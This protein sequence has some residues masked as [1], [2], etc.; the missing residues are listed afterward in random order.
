MARQDGQG[1]AAA[2][3]FIMFFAV[4][5]PSMTGDRFCCSWAGWR[6]AAGL[7]AIPVLLLSLTVSLAS[8]T[9]HLRLAHQSVVQSSVS[10]NVRQH[11]DRD[12]VQWTPP[13]PR[14]TVLEA[15]GFDNRWAPAGP[16]LPNQLWHDTLY[17]RPP[18]SC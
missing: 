11:L 1:F 13:A 5:T 2:R 10:Q 4:R 9:F 14:F 6:R 12:A 8:R 16:P 3:S 18:P 17:N 15:S 7:G